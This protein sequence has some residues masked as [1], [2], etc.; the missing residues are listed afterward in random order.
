MKSTVTLVK[1]CN[2]WWNDNKQYATNG[3]M[4]TISYLRKSE[5]ICSTNVFNLVYRYPR[6]FSF[7]LTNLLLVVLYLNAV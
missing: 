5:D 2:K 1:V 4:T 7:I 6:Q 3:S